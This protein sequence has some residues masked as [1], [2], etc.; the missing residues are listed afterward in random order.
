MATT[1]IEWTDQVWNPIRG[2]SLVSAG[3]RNC[4]AM[5]FAG[6]FSHPG[7][8][9]HGLVEWTTRGPR[10]N[11]EVMLV[12]DKLEE[13]L[14]WR[15]PRR[16]F[17]N[18]MSDLFHD[19][20]PDEYIRDVFTVMGMASKHTFQVL[21]KRSDRME[22][23][24]GSWSASELREDMSEQGIDWPLPNVWLG[25][26]VE[27]QEFVD[28]RVPALL[29]VP[30]AVRFV[31]AEPLLGEL[32]LECVECPVAVAEK[33]GHCMAHCGVCVGPDGIGTE[34]C[35]TNGFFD[36]LDEGI[37]WVIVGCETGP[38]SQVR[39]MQEHWVRSL[40]RQCQMSGTAF[41][42]KQAKDEKGKLLSL[43]LLDGKQ[44]NQYPDEQKE[45]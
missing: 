16:V 24:F 4:Y 23:W 3:C 8:P 45:G 28:K 32:D 40:R 9:Y 34:E 44:W 20:V 33:K 21:T 31:S 42:Y 11:G 25:V 27:T 5:K 1:G 22:Q 37:D 19:K 18:S 26:S 2:C 12:P 7:Q 15:K 13:P 38:K 6:R 30:A 10:W 17:V 39:D 36:A 43:P 14:R 35:C 29:S 41:F